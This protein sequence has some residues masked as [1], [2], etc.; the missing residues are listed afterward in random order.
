MSA[1]ALFPAPKELE[2]VSFVHDGP[3]V[4][5]HLRT[6]RPRVSCPECGTSTHRVH[7]RY[8]RM[9]ADL[10]WHGSAVK[11]VLQTRRFF[12]FTSVCSR[13][14][15]AERLPETAAHYARRTLRLSTALDAISLALGG[16]A[17]AR[18][19]GR[20]GM[21]VSADT[22]LRRLLA[23]TPAAPTVAPRVLAV[24]DWAWRKG[25]VYGTIL[26]DLEARCPV[27]LLP[28][29]TADTLARWLLQHPGVEIV[30]RDRSTE[31]SRAIR[32]AAPHVREVADRWHL[33]H[34][35]RQAL[36]RFFSASYARL[37]Q[38]MSTAEPVPPV[39]GWVP[40]RRTRAEE[41]AQ[42]AARQERLS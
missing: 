27:D 30:A 9:L 35:L 26:M 3:G 12:C 10:P 17:G 16:E 23:G 14:I 6:R 19:A 21:T 32:E 18:L 15:F 29:R 2:F 41:A 42:E 31:Y 40:P 22:L 25:Q 28:D 24:D 33:L 34:N 20:L 13:R 36:E 8:T 37:K 38:H 4:V 1:V 39:S 7:S 5:I 11:V